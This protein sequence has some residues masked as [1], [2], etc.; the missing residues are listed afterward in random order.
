MARA[1]NIKP[2]FFTNDVLAQCEYGARLVFVG[3]WCIADREGRL[4]DRPLRIKAQIM[5]FDNCDID[6]LL[7]QLATNGFITRY[8][9]A[10]RKYI[11]VNN[12]RKHQNPHVKEGAS[13][14]PAPDLHHTS[15][16]DSLLLIPDSLISDPLC[17]ARKRKR[18]SNP[19]FE[20]NYS[21]D[22]I[23]FWL[24]FPSYRK[25]AKPVAWEA[26][27]SAV[28]RK[29]PQDIIAAAKAYAASPLGRSEF[30]KGP[31][32]WLNQDC[33]DD[34]PASWQRNGD[35]KLDQP[36][37]PLSADELET[38]NPIDGGGT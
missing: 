37:R 32:P 12:F 20:R 19:P 18:K 9:V 29:G 7:S 36:A 2:G 26:W 5:P 35:G 21:V 3:L 4:E 17:S 34:D 25:G 6:S 38:W 33:W 13:T 11:Q 1:R 10:N 24:A 8:E 28:T 27:K 22:F 15:P 16:A 31:A 30:C 23:E 14:I